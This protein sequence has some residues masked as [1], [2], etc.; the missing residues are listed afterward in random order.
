MS[1]AKAVSSFRYKLGNIPNPADRS[2]F[3]VE[4]QTLQKNAIRNNLVA[5]I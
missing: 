5:T 4:K 3:L 1:A 2:K